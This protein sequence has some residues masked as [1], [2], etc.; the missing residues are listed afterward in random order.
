MATSPLRLRAPK[1]DPHPK[2]AELRVSGWTTAKIA[3]AIGASVRE[4]ARWSA[5]DSRPIRIYENLLASLPP[6]PPT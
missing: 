1:Y 6:S 4:V 3:T 5:G 2:I